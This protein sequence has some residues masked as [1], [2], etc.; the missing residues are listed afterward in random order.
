MNI[1]KN[2]DFEAHKAKVRVGREGRRKGGVE[3][4]GDKPRYEPYSF[5][6]KTD[7]HKRSV[8][9]CSH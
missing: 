8:S 6:L 9:P 4:P 7:H 1:M 2:S 5:D 3:H